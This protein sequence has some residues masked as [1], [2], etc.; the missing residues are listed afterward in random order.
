MFNFENATI[1][2]NSFKEDGVLIMPKFTGEHKD[3][4]PLFV[5]NNRAVPFYV[6]VSNGFPA[7]VFLHDQELLQPI[8][9]ASPNIIDLWKELREA[10]VV[11]FESLVWDLFDVNS[12]IVV[13]IAQVDDY[14]DNALEVSVTNLTVLDDVLETA[15]EQ[16]FVL[17]K[18]MYEL[19]MKVNN[20][21]KQELFDLF[22][23]MGDT[24]SYAG[25]VRNTI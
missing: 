16:D 11:D 24:G 20:K 19:Y 1:S 9:D 15:F 8:F 5:P 22:K 10:R 23:E 2:S 7:A 17:S 18:K 6:T 21:S 12:G 4:P 3:L 14:Y 25:K 13:N